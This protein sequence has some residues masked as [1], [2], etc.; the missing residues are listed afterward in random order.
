MARPLLRF[1]LGSALAVSLWA[2]PY[3][4]SSTAQGLEPLPSART[5]VDRFISAIGGQQ[6]FAT[7][8]SVHATGTI[9]IAQQGISGTADLMTARPNKSLLVV[10]ITGIGRIETG[11][12]GKVGW[13]I[14]PQSGPALATGQELTEMAEEA[15]F[16][17][18]LRRPDQVKEMTTVE[19]TEF[20]HRPVYK[21]KIV[22]PSGRE[23]FSYFDTETGLDLGHEGKRT[24]RMGTLPSIETFRDYKAFG[25]VKQAT[26][27]VDDVLGFQQVV[28]I[29]TC[30]YNN[31][32][33]DAFELPPAIKAL[34][35]TK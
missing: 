6:A 19:K 2:V 21:L 24:T 27:I 16:D 4:A 13:N 1:A 31:V 29:T 11:Y 12:D 9:E 7:V 18:P 32:P 17:A 30:V 5:V 20:D 15:W 10:D 25:G 28:H 22:F 8:N 34:I 35:K 3:G 33:A 23:E 14:D 26:T